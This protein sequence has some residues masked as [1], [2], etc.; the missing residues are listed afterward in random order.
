MNDSD[1]HLF[2]IIL[3]SIT[4]LLS[5]QILIIRKHYQGKLRRIYKYM[6]FGL[7]ASG[8]MVLIIGLTA[9]LWQ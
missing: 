8:I 6:F 9:P 4:I 1:I 7:L 5:P 3:G 2:I